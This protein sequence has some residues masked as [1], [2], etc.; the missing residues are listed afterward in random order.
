MSGPEMAVYA[1]AIGLSGSILL[2]W[3]DSSPAGLMGWAGFGLSSLVCGYLAQMA[4]GW[5]NAWWIK[6]VKA[7]PLSPDPEQQSDEL[8]AELFPSSNEARRV[9][10]RRA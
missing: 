10:R 9:A 6:N 5:L 8:Y 7:L 4:I 2:K 3:R 1:G